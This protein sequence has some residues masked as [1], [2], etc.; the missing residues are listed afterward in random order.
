ML[1][2][3]MQLKHI[4]N[5]EI[6]LINKMLLDVESHDFCRISFGKWP[7]IKTASKANAFDAVLHSHSPKLYG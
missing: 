2:T 5:N 7:I 3:A 6:I 4:E 1:N